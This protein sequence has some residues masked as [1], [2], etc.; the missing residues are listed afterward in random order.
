MTVWFTSDLHLGHGFVAKLRGFPDVDAHDSAILEGWATSVHKNDQVWVLGDLAV[1]SSAIR[2][3]QL[4]GM[5]RALP[6]AKHLIVGNHDAGH[7]MHRDSHKFQRHY[8]QAFESVQA[9]ARRRINGT[10]VLLSHFPYEG[11]HTDEPRHSQY[12]LRDEGR[13]LLHGHIHSPQRVAPRQVH[14]GVDAWDLRPVA[15]E[16]VADLIE[17]ERSRLTDNFEAA[18]GLLADRQPVGGYSGTE[19]R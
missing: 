3:E 14:V 8:L 18:R 11:D 16:T 6:G 12:R 1:T 15:L 10:E 2:V 5:L 19:H 13:W 9:F 17:A 4:M 7:P